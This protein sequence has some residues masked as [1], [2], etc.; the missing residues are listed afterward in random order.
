[1]KGH[2]KHINNKFQLLLAK[3]QIS[4]TNDKPI[5]YKLLIRT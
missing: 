4:Y 2:L 1:M 5:A 3:D